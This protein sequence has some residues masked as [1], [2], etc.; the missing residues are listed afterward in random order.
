M[1][2]SDFLKYMHAEKRCSQHTLVAY[3]YDLESIAAY[4]LGQYDT[5]AIYNLTGRQVR[6]WMASLLEQKI[7][8]RSVK[9][10][11]S[12]YKSYLSFCES[13]GLKIDETAKN[14]AAPK[15]PQHLPT[16]VS[17]SQIDNLFDYFTFDNSFTGKRD[18]LVMAMLY[19]TGMR[20]SELV[21][22]KINDIDTYSS[23][24]KVLGK[25]NKERIIPITPFLTHILNTYIQERKALNIDNVYLVVTDLGKMAYRMNP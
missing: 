5:Q 14:L 20:L 4:A 24:V 9:R 10:K 6:S 23:T 22:L 17:Q 16:V 8:P 21:G 3:K 13:N 2:I 19:S 18:H 15:I 7:G 25:R 11:L 1:E 12:T